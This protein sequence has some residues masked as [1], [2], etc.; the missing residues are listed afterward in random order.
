MNT[1]EK[2]KKFLEFL[3]QQQINDY[4][5]V[6][7]EINCMEACVSPQKKF[8][9]NDVL[10]RFSSEDLKQEFVG[11]MTKRY[12]EFRKIR[13]MFQNSKSFFQLFDKFHPEINV[14][15]KSY[16]LR[17]VQNAFVGKKKINNFLICL[18]SDF[19][20]FIM[21][22]YGISEYSALYIGNELLKMGIFKSYLETEVLQ[23]SE[24]VYIMTPLMEI[25]GI[26]EE[27]FKPKSRKKSAS[28]ASTTKR[29]SLF[30]IDLY[31]YKRKS[32]KRLSVDLSG[33]KSTK[34]LP[35]KSTT[36][37]SNG[38][39]TTSKG[40]LYDFFVSLKK[41]ASMF[42]GTPKKSTKVYGV[43]ISELPEAFPSVFS[44]LTEF[45]EKWCKKV[46][47]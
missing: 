3:T 18:G 5:K 22:Q 31:S 44:S 13:K 36:S 40:G 10:Y 11:K 25:P 30:N 34:E 27:H 47:S 43:K 38:T 9:P 19:I 39:S 24:L 21:K 12:E 26:V 37:T 16:K 7:L 15:E 42:M 8:E 14:G 35:K 46:S 6:L 4:F 23:N 17:K 29:R 28:F 32:Q 2:N 33:S 41:S 20:E 45:I 1:L